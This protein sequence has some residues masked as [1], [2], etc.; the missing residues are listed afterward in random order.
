MMVT[1]YRA[2]LDFIR[3]LGINKI[4]ELPEY[5]NLHSHENLIQLLEKE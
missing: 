3:Y 1:K 2:S 4:E 5:Q